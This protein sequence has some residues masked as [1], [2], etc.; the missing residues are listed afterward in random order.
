MSQYM[1]FDSDRIVEQ[2]RLRQV[3]AFCANA[4]TIQSLPY[5]HTHDKDINEA[6]DQNLDS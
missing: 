3:C 6:S 4:Q 5:S 1:N 2:Q